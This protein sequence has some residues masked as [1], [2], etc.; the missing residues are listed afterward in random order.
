LLDSFNERSD[1]AERCYNTSVFY[2]PDGSV[3]ATYRKIHLFDVDVPNGPR[4]FE[5]TT[6]KPGEAAAV[7]A[8]P[9]ARFGLSICYDLRFAELYR[10]LADGGAE[11]LMIPTRSPPPTRKHT[12]EPLLR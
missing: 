5:S 4:F 10:K 12:R 11:V 7:V 6:C 3:L 9:L 1:E 2:G 8:T